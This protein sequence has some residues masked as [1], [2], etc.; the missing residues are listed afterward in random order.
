MADFE[1]QKPVF[2]DDKG[3]RGRWTSYLGVGAA[4]VVTL[5]LGFFTTKTQ[6][7]ERDLI[8]LIFVSFVSF[9]SLW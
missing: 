5:L 4:T 6:R 8:L 2:F 7:T 3:H 1:G 9:V